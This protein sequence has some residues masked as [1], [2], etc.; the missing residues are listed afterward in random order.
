[1]PM[2]PAVTMGRAVD[3]VDVELVPD[4]RLLAAYHPA[5][6]FGEKVYGGDG[7]FSQRPA[8]DAAGV[9][10]RDSAVYKSREQ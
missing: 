4:A 2:V 8:E 5:K 3:F 1:M 7:K 6:I 10:D 9:R